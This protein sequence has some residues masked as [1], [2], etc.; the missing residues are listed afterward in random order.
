MCLLTNQTKAI[1]TKEDIVV[2]KIILYPTENTVESVFQHFLYIK[3]KVEKTKFTYDKKIMP[4]DSKEKQEWAAENPK[5]I[6]EEGFH[7][8]FTIQRLE[9]NLKDW[10]V[11]FPSYNHHIAEFIIPKGSKLYKGKGDLGISNQIKYTGNIIK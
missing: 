7:F 9:A 5:L 2:Y 1:I 4:F 6:I 11:S 8:A 10:L 3:E